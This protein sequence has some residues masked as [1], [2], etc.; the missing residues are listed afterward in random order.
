V[1]RIRDGSLLSEKSM[2]VIA[3][4]A[5]ANDF[6]VWVELVDTSGRVGFVLEDGTVRDA[7]AA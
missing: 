4:M 6:Q 1:L 3:E 5:E 2:A 7:E